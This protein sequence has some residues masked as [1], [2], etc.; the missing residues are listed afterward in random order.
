MFISI[1]FNPLKPFE[2]S[3]P[4]FITYILLCKLHCRSK[5]RTVVADAHL[6]KLMIFSKSKRFNSSFTNAIPANLC[7]AINKINQGLIVK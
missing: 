6:T 5:G 7:I 4:V 2:N 1:S 3:S